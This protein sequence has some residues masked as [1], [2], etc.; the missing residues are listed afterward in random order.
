MPLAPNGRFSSAR[1]SFGFSLSVGLFLL[2]FVFVVCVAILLCLIFLPSKVSM[3]TGSLCAE[4]NAIG[5]ALADDLS[6]RR[7]ELKVRDSKT[8]FWARAT[9]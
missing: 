4:R 8:P 2:F 9:Q 5:S 6:L 3:P 7:T 1:P